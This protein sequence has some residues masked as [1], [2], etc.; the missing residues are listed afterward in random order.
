MAVTVSHGFSCA[1]ADDPTDA[2]AGKVLPSHWNASHTV[3]NA[4]DKTGDTMTGS[5]A[6]NLGTITAQA[7]GWSTSQT[8]N[9]G[10]V[11]FTAAQINITDTASDASS[12]ALEVKTGGISKFAVTSIGIVR[13]AFG[14]FCTDNMGIGTYGG[15]GLWGDLNKFSVSNTHIIAWSNSSNAY[16]GTLDI[17]LARNA[18]GVLELNNATPGTFRD[19]KA[20]NVITPGVTVAS[21][22]GAAQG[23]RSFVTDATQTMTAGIGAVVVGG[24]ANNVPVYYDGT[25]WRIG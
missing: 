15:W 7:A 13:N 14:F 6:I 3:A 18:A 8:W 20:R 25:N 21:L 11:L 16:T 24:G 2:A 9:N 22:A 10:A 5:L 17:A 4:L 1:I 23:A 12:L 19:L